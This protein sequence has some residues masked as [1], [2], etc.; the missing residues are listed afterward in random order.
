MPT[1]APTMVPPIIV[2]KL[3]I[4]RSSSVAMSAIAIPI[5]ARRLP[6]F[7]VAGE[8]SERRPKMNSSAA[9]TYDA[10]MRA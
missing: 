7:A 9:T 10:C 4:C 3:T 5:A 8:L 6:V 2:Q 1:A